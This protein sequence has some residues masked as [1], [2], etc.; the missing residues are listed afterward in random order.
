MQLLKSS[1]KYLE[2]CHC[3]NQKKKKLLKVYFITELMTNIAEINKVSTLFN[4]KHTAQYRHRV[5]T[6]FVEESFHV[7]LKT[8]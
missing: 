6:Y 3:N 2:H 7:N 4:R 1:K 8:F 5:L